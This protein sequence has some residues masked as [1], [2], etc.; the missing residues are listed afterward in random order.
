ML[1][2]SVVMP[3]LNEARTLANCI[4]NAQ[5][6]LQQAGIAQYEIIIADNGST[7]DSLQIAAS[8]Q[9]SVVQVTTKGYGAALHAGISAAQYE[10]IV[11][12]DADESY[13]FGD[14]PNFLPAMQQHYSLIVGNRFAGGI[15][16]GAM[17]FYTVIWAHR[18][19]HGL[20]G[21]RL[22]WH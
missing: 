13:N 22:A 8:F 18:L 21:S 4:R 7:D 3:C 2:I 14:L 15:D 20:A 16:K 6:A 19:F 12:A 17:P 11:F 9:A 10:W 5:Q 1:S